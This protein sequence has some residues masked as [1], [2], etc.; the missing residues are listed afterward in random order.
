MGV[1]NPLDGTDKNFLGQVQLDTKN[2]GE[3]IQLEFPEPSKLCYLTFASVGVFDMFTLEADDVALD[4]EDYFPGQSSIRDISLSQSPNTYPGH[5]D[6]TKAALELPYAKKWEIIATAGDGIQ[7]ENC[8]VCPIPEPS[9][10]VL[11][12]VGIGA[13]GISVLRRRK[14]SAE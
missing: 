3:F 14:A 9:T 1:L 8:G 4:M 11:W 5:V 7:L 12:L 10:M 2:G 13:V 6:F